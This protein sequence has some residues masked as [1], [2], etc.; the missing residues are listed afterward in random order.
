M[1]AYYRRNNI[2]RIEDFLKKFPIGYLRVPR[3]GGSF[4]EG[5][6]TLSKIDQFFFVK[7]STSNKTWILNVTFC[8]NL[9]KDI[10]LS[11]L[12]YSDIDDSIIKDMLAV[13]D[14]GFY[15]EN[16]RLHIRLLEEKLGIKII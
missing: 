2:V 11:D 10:K 7:Y 9:N 13:L 8:D 6:V 14:E 16:I 1:L 5:S 12:S 3:T 4:S 15:S